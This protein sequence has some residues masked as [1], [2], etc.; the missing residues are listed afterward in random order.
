MLL[1]YTTWPDAESASA[2]ARALVEERLAA[3]ATLLG[4]AQS[5]YRWNGAATQS[6]EAVMLI[7]TTRDAAPQTLAR[8]RALHPYEVPCILAISPE[9]SASAPDFLAWVQASVS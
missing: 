2:A 5:V 9:A 1:Y 3:C 6:S 7:K 4:G 8:L